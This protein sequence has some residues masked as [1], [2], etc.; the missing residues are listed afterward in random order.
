MSLFSVI[1]KWKC[2][3]FDAAFGQWL[4]GCDLELSELFFSRFWGYFT[5]LSPF[6]VDI[7]NGTLPLLSKMCKRQTM[8]PLF[9]TEICN[10]S[11]SA[12]NPLRRASQV[13]FWNIWLFSTCSWWNVVDIFF[14]LRVKSFLI[15]W[16]IELQVKCSGSLYSLF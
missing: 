16:N 11:I 12:F 6:S 15:N 13:W 4:C 5:P 8:E 14:L 1:D 9:L 3:K 10:F 2:A 7:M